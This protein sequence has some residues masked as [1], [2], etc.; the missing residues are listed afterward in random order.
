MSGVAK[1]PPCEV[2]RLGT[3][4]ICLVRKSREVDHA[5]P[6]VRAV[7]DVEP[8][9]VVLAVGLAQRRVVRVSPAQR[10]LRR[11]SRRRVAIRV[12]LPCR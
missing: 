4:R 8:A 11:R 12:T 7:V 3:C 1:M 2:C 10:V 9:A 6:A 5:D